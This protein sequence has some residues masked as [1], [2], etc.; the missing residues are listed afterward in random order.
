VHKRRNWK[1]ADFEAIRKYVGKNLE[2]PDTAHNRAAIDAQVKRIEDTL[3]AAVESHV[4]WARPCEAAKEWWT[5]ECKNAVALVRRTRRAWTQSMARYGEFRELEVYQA[6]R[7]AL[8]TRNRTIRHAKRKGFREKMDELTSSETAIWKIA[9]WGHL[10]SNVKRESPQ[11]PALKTPGVSTPAVTAEEKVEALSRKFFPAPPEAELQDIDLTIRPREL[12]SDPQVTE[13][14][15]TKALRKVKAW[16]APGPDGLANG[17]LKALRETL[18]PFWIS[19][20]NACLATGYHPER[21]RQARTIA[22]KKPGKSDYTVVGAY[23]PIALLNTTGK[24]LE[25]IVAS[26]LS[27]LAEKHQLLPGVQMGARPGRSTASA[28]ELLTEQ[29]H[30]VWKYGGQGGEG[31]VATILSLDMEGAFD[32]VSSRRLIHILAM[33]GIPQYLRRWAASFMQDRSTSLIIPGHESSIFTISTGIPQGS[34]ASP[35]LFLFYNSEL[36]DICTQPGRALSACGFVDDANILTYGDSTERNCERLAQ[37]HDKCLHWARRHGASFAPA[38]YELIHLTRATKKFNLEASLKIGNQVIKPKSHIRILGVQLDTKLQWGPHL[39]KLEA[40]MTRRIMALTKLTAST[41]GARV[42]RAKRIYNAVVRPAWMYGAKVWCHP[43]A[44][45]HGRKGTIK[46]LQTIQNNCLRRISGA[47]RATPQDILELETGIPPVDIYLETRLLSQCEKYAASPGAKIVAAACHKIRNRLQNRTQ[48][49]T[50]ELKIPG[51][52]SAKWAQRQIQEARAINA[53]NRKAGDPPAKAEHLAS[54][55]MVDRWENR[56]KK[57]AAQPN[58][59]RCAALT[60][61]FSTAR[62]DLH[63][64]CTKAESAMVTL[65]RTERIGLRAFLFKQRVPGTGSPLCPCGNGN[66]TAKHMLIHCANLA[67]ARRALFDATGTTSFE[68]MLSDPL[69]ARAAAKWA[70]SNKILEQ[71][72]LV[73]AETRGEE[74]QP[75]ANQQ[76]GSS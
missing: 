72:R 4:P 60:E 41:W 54:V 64:A 45:H 33:K 36:F 55:S 8:D 75:A 47:Y 59:T 67:P 46:K 18:T 35:I 12:A 66:Q 30:T 25:S 61:P 23:R 5:D 28:L 2:G 63:Q 69:K 22:L 50:E 56:W 13:A 11:L 58:H 74:R 34:P 43:A 26:R 19:L 29:V 40:N 73:E 1:K 53:S 39:E 51:I 31:K 49:E 68:V 32:K 16:S 15:I 52:L 27:A 10:K 3:Q 17:L 71:F 62:T 14:D 20:F 57:Y 24:M 44:L 21:F 38:K 37:I 48:N 42:S 7:D 76:A 6:Y 9:R 70:I 65:L